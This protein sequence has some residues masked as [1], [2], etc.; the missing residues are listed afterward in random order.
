VRPY[1][2][3]EDSELQE[4]AAL[5]GYIA[6]FTDRSIESREDL[7]DLFLDGEL[8]LLEGFFF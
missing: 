6:G 4:L 3:F 8:A 1:L 7:Y 2:L 5:G